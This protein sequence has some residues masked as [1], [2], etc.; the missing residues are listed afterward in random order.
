MTRCSSVHEVLDTSSEARPSHK[1]NAVMYT[2]DDYRSFPCRSWSEQHHIKSC[3]PTA[4]SRRYA[5]PSTSCERWHRVSPVIARPRGEARRA[6]PAAFG[7]VQSAAPRHPRRSSCCVVDGLDRGFPDTG[8]RLHSH[9]TGLAVAGDGSCVSRL[10][11][12]MMASQQHG[13]HCRQDCDPTASDHQA[14]CSA[15]HHC[16]RPDHWSYGP[17]LAHRSIAAWDSRVP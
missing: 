4:E 9:R 10:F 3:P 12:A 17:C 16:C 7:A 6:S 15:Q 5:S 11:S 8:T 13:R 14:R 1:I 2:S